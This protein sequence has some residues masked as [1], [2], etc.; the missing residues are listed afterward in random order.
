MTAP[1]YISPIVACRV[2]QLDQAGLR[3]LNGEPWLPRKA[4][5]AGCQASRAGTKVG[6]AEAPHCAHHAPV[7]GCT[8]GIYAAASVAHLRHVGY[9][10]YG[11]HGE[12][13]LWGTIVKHESGWRAQFAYPKSL[14]LPLA[15]LPRSM[16][17]V[18]TWL[19]RLTEYGC[20]I[21]VLGE[22]GIAPLWA[23]EFG[24]NAA[25]ID[26]LLER[27]RTWYGRRAQER[28]IK[29]GDRLAVLGRGIAVVERFED[30]CV[31]ALLWNRSLVRIERN[32]IVWDAGN[33][34]WEAASVGVW[35]RRG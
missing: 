26:R 32:H 31:C 33:G 11:I 18:E 27:C 8:C 2:W 20:D 34:R 12:V 3:S 29:C 23:K 30:S 13:Y 1:D 35:K 9:D 21:S 22:E 15:M 10:Q 24:Y 16:G 14:V 7:A 17:R 28:R 6:G 25:A 4:L 19:Q 5:V